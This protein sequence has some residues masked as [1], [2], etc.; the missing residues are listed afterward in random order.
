MGFE[1]LFTKFIKENICGVP[2][3]VNMAKPFKAKAMVVSSTPK[4]KFHGNIVW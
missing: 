4:Q 2:V 3:N 1:V